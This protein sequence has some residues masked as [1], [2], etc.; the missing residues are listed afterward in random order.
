[1]KM[2]EDINN[3]SIVAIPKDMERRLDILKSSLTIE[4]SITKHLA[5]L[6][7]INKYESITLGNKS[8]ALS[9]KTKTDLLIDLGT[10]NKNEQKKIVYF[11][12]IRNQFVHNINCKNFTD[13]HKYNESTSKA[14]LKLY[15]DKDDIILE[16]Q[17][18]IAYKKLSN[19]V[20]NI[21]SN[22]FKNVKKKIEDR[23]GGE[24]YE[25]AFNNLKI[26]IDIVLESINNNS[27]NI[28]TE[29]PKT[30]FTKHLKDEIK[31]QFYLLSRKK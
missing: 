14:L 24:I 30:I 16:E 29:E 26:S 27:F 25:K 22:V 31:N 28:S 1:M 8:T 20:A 18:I 15:K 12:E 13:F 19:D 10:L 21:I 9:L 2:I 17:L 7:D 6:L 3:I 4:E 5:D 23:I 11:F